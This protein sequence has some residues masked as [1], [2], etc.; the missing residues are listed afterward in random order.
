LSYLE[1]NLANLGL[2]IVYTSLRSGKRC[3][4]DW[5]VIYVSTNTV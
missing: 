1:I 3:L 2:Y 5:A 4:I